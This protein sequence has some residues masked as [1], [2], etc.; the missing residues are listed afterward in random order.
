MFVRVMSLLVALALLGVVAGCS[1][2]PEAEM[3]AGE[4][5]LNKAQLAEAQDYAPAIYQQAL[6]SL[7]AAKV[8]IQKQDG[9]FSLFRDYDRAKE[10][11][12]SA[13][14]IG[15]QAI[16]EAQTAKE[17]T[18]IQDSVLAYTIDTLMVAA[19]AAIDKAPRGK[20]TRADIELLKTDLASVEP[21][22]AAAVADVQ[23]GKYLAA[24]AKF[25]A[26]ESQLNRII[27]DVA[28]AKAKVSGN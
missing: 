16:A 11:L 17:Q 14:T 25:E 28:A 27:A 22:Y 2:A 19:K 20:G 10:L 15:D 7:N 6:D 12:T 4:E 5:S 13:Q 21:A 23:A 9:K 24:R 1:K 18:R 26:I 3:Q 8:E